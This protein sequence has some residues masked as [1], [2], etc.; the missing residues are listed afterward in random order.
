[1]GSVLG[2]HN[3]CNA[4][5]GCKK[6]HGKLVCRDKKGKFYGLTVSHVLMAPCMKPKNK[7][8]NS[9]T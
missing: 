1:M 5:R 2:Y 4:C 7:R 8:N 9:E 6:E 3:F